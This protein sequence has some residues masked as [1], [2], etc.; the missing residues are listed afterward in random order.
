[1][2]ADERG[3]ASFRRRRDPA[4]AKIT[5]AAM[6]GRGTRYGPGSR[7]VLGLD[8]VR[9]N[10]T[11]N[12]AASLASEGLSRQVR[13]TR[14]AERRASDC[15]RRPGVLGG[16][17]TVSRSDRRERCGRRREHAA[18]TIARPAAVQPVARR[19]RL[20]AEGW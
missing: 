3:S 1:V 13:A 6:R 14:R 5:L 17:A 16:C 2:S 15:R 11:G 12:R 10:L 7:R 18:V 4:I 9:A 20:R 19:E 8:Q